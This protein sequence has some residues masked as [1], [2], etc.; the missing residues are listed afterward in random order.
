MNQ[1]LADAYALL[2]TGTLWHNTLL[3]SPKHPCK[4]FADANPGEAALVDA[5]VAALAADGAAAVPAVATATGKGLVGML[6]ALAPAVTPPPPP[7]PPPPSGVIKG[8]SPGAKIMSAGDAKSWEIP[9]IAAC[10]G[11]G[12]LVRLDYAGSGSDGI[13]QACVEAGL[14]PLLL[15]GGTLH[16]IPS[17]AAHASAVTAALTKWKGVCQYIEVG[18]NEPNLNGQTPQVHAELVKA[19][20]AAAKKVD[21]SVTVLNGGLAPN[22]NTLTHGTQLIPLIKGAVDHFNLHLYEDATV[23]GSWNNWDRCF[24]PESLGGAKSLRQVLDAN[25]MSAIPISST[26][27][28]GRESDIGETAQAKYVTDAY[29]DFATRRKNGEQV[30][31]ILTYCMRDDEYASGWGLCRLD[32]SRRPAWTQAHAA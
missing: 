24:H 9:E 12:A 22:N 27:S 21:P 3:G 16:S 17:P 18:G 30:G 15:I 11:K 1:Q 8:C 31:F 28:G 32:H 2:K 25:G 23:R 10:F 4:G 5:Y 29:A 26:E 19:G 6:A 20:Y 13:V 14:S 7:P